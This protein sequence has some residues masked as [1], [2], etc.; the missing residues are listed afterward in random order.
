MIDDAT[1]DGAAPSRPHVWRPGPGRRPLLLLH[2]TGGDEQSL[3]ALADRLAPDA[4]LL[5]PRGTVLENG[6]VT[7]F[8]RRVREGV[9]DEADLRVRADELSAFLRTAGM[10]YRAP[11]GSWVAVGFSNGANMAAAMLLL[12]P[13]QLAGA[14]LISAL[15]PFT[16]GPGT[17]DLSGKQIALVYGLHDR[18]VP[19]RRSRE[20]AAQLRHRGAHVVEL[21]HNGGHVVADSVLHELERFVTSMSVSLRAVVSGAHNAAPGSNRTAPGSAETA[22]PG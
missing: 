8:F 12:H 16:T 1:A 18:I 13:D 9:I 17:V 6:S 21:A 19:A 15:P 3:V 22:P 10:H 14:V 4:P 20:L 2:G 7:R 11:P 5:S